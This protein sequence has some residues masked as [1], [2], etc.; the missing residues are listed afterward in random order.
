MKK[1]SSRALLFSSIIELLKDKGELSISDI[2]KEK[3]LNWETVRNALNTLRDIEVLEEK[4]IKNK[5]VFYLKE[6]DIEEEKTDT[7]LGLPLTKDQRDRTKLLFKKIKEAWNKN[8]TDKPLNKTFMQ[9]IAVRVLK[10][11]ENKEIPYGWYLFGMMSVLQ[12]DPS[13]EIIIEKDLLGT[14]LDSE[15]DKVVKQFKTYENTDQLMLSQYQEEGND[16][17][18]T[19]LKLAQDFSNPFKIENLQ[20][21]KI[22][23]RNLIFSFKATKDNEEINELLNGFTSLVALLIKKLNINDLEDIR[24]KIL[25][26]FNALWKCMATYNLYESLLED[27]F[28]EKDILKRKYLLRVIPLIQI[29]TDYLDFLKDFLPKE[30]LITDDLSK[31]KGVIRE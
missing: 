1:R 13:Q 22:R 2:S 30:K 20:E 8:I 21:I 25:D 23:L 19:K 24:D 10:N 29:C 5:R 12:C 6:F 15:I 9:K 28:F 26:A 11:T 27:K 18:L 16:L 4:N 7:L 3:N 31:F 17:Y 14:T